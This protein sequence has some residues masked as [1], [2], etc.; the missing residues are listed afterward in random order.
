MNR[1][2][3]WK[4][5]PLGITVNVKDKQQALFALSDTALQLYPAQCHTIYHRTSNILPPLPFIKN[6][7]YFLD[8]M[9]HKPFFRLLFFE[10]QYLT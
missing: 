3:P 10:H 8:I 7:M 9:N 1:L 5:T 4:A 2:C 6:N